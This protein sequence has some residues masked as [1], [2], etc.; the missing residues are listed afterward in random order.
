MSRFALGHAE[1]FVHGKWAADLGR[2]QRPLL[3]SVPGLRHAL[4]LSSA[5]LAVAVVVSLRV[6]A[7]AMSWHSSL[8]T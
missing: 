6:G 1:Q 3:C 7:F 4:A 2:R 8:F 5:Q